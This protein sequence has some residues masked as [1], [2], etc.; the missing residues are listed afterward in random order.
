LPARQTRRSLLAY[1]AA[2]GACL[3]GILLSTGTEPRSLRRAYASLAHARTIGRAFLERT[4]QESGRDKLLTSIFGRARVGNI[5]DIRAH[6]S[7]AR[8]ADFLAGRVTVIRGWVMSV[9]EARWC[10]LALF[11][12]DPP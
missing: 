6:L 12:N 1:A 11:V 5:A 7:R 10:A 4:P 8:N 3:P 9:T 2:T